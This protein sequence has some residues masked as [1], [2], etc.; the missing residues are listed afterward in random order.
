MPSVSALGGTKRFRAEEL[1]KKDLRDQIGR[2]SLEC[3]QVASLHPAVDSAFGVAGELADI[4]RCHDVCLLFQQLCIIGWQVF[5]K[6]QRDFVELYGFSVRLV[7]FAIP[8]RDCLVV[9][10]ADFPVLQV[11]HGVRLADSIAA[12]LLSAVRTRYFTALQK[13]AGCLLADMTELIKLLFCQDLRDL[14]PV[15]FFHRDTPH[16]QSV[17][18]DLPVYRCPLRTGLFSPEFS[19]FSP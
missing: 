18:T 6:L 10:R 16:S 12:R 17:G 15:D 2:A 3:P 9:F 11:G 14:V 19:L 7:S 8:P 13:K 1:Y 5:Q 4:I